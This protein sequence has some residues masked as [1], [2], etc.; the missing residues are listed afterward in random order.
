LKAQVP[1]NTWAAKTWGRVC[2][3]S[4]LTNWLHIDNKQI[5]FHLGNSSQK[6]LMN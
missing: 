4:H 1:H 2:W 3:Q 5:I 6:K